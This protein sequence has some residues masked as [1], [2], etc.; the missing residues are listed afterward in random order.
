MKAAAAYPSP[1]SR[2]PFPP[3]NSYYFSK[4]LVVVQVLFQGLLEFLMPLMAAA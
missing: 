4:L 2:S 1:L 3:T